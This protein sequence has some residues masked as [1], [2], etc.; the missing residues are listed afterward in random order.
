MSFNPDEQY[1]RGFDAGRAACV[2][3]LEDLRSKHFV[4]SYAYDLTTEAIHCA[5]L[6][7][8]ENNHEAPH[9]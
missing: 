7:Q 3:A 6:V 2:A 5:A 9:G 4:R 1:E 8:F